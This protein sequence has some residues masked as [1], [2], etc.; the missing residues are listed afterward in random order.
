VEKQNASQ[1]LTLPLLEILLRLLKQRIKAA[2]FN[3]LLKL[4]I[5]HLSLEF[6]KPYVS[7]GAHGKF[8]DLSPHIFKIPKHYSKG[9]T[10]E[11]SGTL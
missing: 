7:K 5:P 3:I 8:I 9:L 11:C 10:P 2:S 6:L 1:W 4:P